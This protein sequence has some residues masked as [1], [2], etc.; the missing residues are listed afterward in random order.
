[1]IRHKVRMVA[2]GFSLNPGVDYTEVFSP[3]SK[4]SATRLLFSLLVDIDLHLLLVALKNVFVNAS[5]KKDIY[6]EQAV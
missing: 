1:M 4:Y 6:I 5:L 3:A 2:K